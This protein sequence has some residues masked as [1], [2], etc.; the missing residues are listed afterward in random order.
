MADSLL[1]YFAGENGR[2][3]IEALRREGLKMNS[4]DDKVRLSDKLEG[5]TVVVSGNFSISRE[6]MKALIEAH[7]GKNSGSVSGKTTYLLA[8]EKAGAEKL[9]KAEK[10]GTRIISE[11]DFYKIVEN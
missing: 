5:A 10:L 8:G 6:A 7:G 4:E 1:A 2:R 9:K 11:D 3:T